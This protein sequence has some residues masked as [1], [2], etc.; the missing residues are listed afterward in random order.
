MNSVLAWVLTKR[1]WTL[2]VIGCSAA[3]EGRYMKTAWTPMI[4]I[5]VSEN[6]VLCVKLIAV[7]MLSFFSK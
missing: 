4:W 1:T 7:I 6:Y 5:I 2:T 3:V